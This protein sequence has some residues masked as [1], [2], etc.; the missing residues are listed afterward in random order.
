MMLSAGGVRPSSRSLAAGIDCA[1]V[2]ND[3]T[4]SPDFSEASYRVEA[5]IELRDIIAG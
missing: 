3:F 5:L 2:R 1:I 4:H